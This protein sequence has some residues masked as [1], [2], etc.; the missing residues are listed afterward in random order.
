MTTA[1]TKPKPVSKR[2]RL[3]AQN[4]SVL[5]MRRKSRAHPVPEVAE[6]DLHERKD[7]R[8]RPYEFAI[9]TG[10]T[11]TVVSEKLAAEAGWTPITST[12]VFGIGG[13]GKS[14]RS[15]TR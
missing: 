11:Q 9:D 13:A 15:C 1:S 10:A 2:S 8:Q 6:S 4:K 7:Q 14:R 12:M 3:S 5:W